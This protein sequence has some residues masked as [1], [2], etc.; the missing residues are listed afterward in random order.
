MVFRRDESSDFASGDWDSPDGLSNPEKLGELVGDSQQA[1]VAWLHRQVQALSK[2]AVP[3]DF[4]NKVLNALQA[5]HASQSSEGETP[6][7]IFRS[8]TLP[9]EVELG[10][11]S[12]SELA[13][14]SSLVPAGHSLVS[15]VTVTRPGQVPFAAKRSLATRLSLAVGLAACLLLMIGLVGLLRRGTNVW[16]EV[17]AGVAVRKGD[18]AEEPPRLADVRDAYVHLWREFAVVEHGAESDRN[19]PV[20]IELIENEHRRTIDRLF[21]PLVSPPEPIHVAFVLPAEQM[22]TT[23]T[24]LRER[25]SAAEVPALNQLLPVSEG[26]P[27]PFFEA[28]EPQHPQV[29][30]ENRSS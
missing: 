2:P 24:I 13:E 8:P 3:D 5:S 10:E 9:L 14:D 27:L 25:I 12:E 17:P 18:P 23:G 4:A 29:P 30:T 21:E 1:E 22:L 15:G 28:E 6:S 20:A 19:E 7:D 16:N 26:F 11:V